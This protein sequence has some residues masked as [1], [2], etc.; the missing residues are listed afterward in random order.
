MYAKAYS[1]GI[2]GKI[3]VALDA[4]RYL[5]RKMDRALVALAYLATG[6]KTPCPKLVWMVP[7]KRIGIAGPGFNGLKNTFKDAFFLETAVYFVCEDT[8]RIG[9]DEP[10]I[11]NFGR[12]YTQHLLPLLR[13]SLVALRVAG[14]VASGLPFPVPNVDWPDRLN[15]FEDLFVN[16]DDATKDTLADMERWVQDIADRGHSDQAPDRVARFKKLVG[17]SYEMLSQKALKEEHSAKWRHSMTPRIAYGDVT[18][19]DDRMDSPTADGQRQCKIKW[20]R[21][22]AFE[23]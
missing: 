2:E 3:D 19:D 23:V 4:I 11:M 20:V 5:G 8:H 7:Q 21:Q 16:V 15:F 14:A 22:L 13:L 6:E 10:M 9:H 1:E 18:N 17:G 12:K